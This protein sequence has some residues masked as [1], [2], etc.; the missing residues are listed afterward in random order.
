MKTLYKFKFVS[1]F[2]MLVLGVNQLSAQC[3]ASFTYTDMGNGVISFSNTSSFPDSSIF[4]VWEMSNGSYATGDNPSQTFYNGWYEVCLTIND[5]IFGGTCTSTI[6][7]SVEVTSGIA[8]PIDSCTIDATYTVVDNGNGVYSFV[9]TVTGGTPP[10]SYSWQFGD[11]TDS[12]IDNP[13]HTYANDGILNVCLTVIDS[14]TN[15]SSVYCQN[16]SVMGDPCG[17]NVYAAD[18]LQYGVFEAYNVSVNCFWDFGDGE[19]SSDS[20]NYQEHFYSSPGTY[21]YCVTI[22]NCPLICD[23]ILIGACNLVSNFS[24]T[25][26]GNGNYSFTNL[27]SGIA[28]TF[29]WNFGDGNTSNNTNPNHTFNANGVYVVVLAITDSIGGCIDYYTLTINV[30]GVLNSTPCNAGFSMYTDSISSGV[31]VVNS[32]TGSNLT[33]FWDFGDGNTSTQ[34]YPSYTYST[35]GPFELCL[36]VTG[37][38][39]CTSTY[40][41]SISAGGTVFKGGG[42]TINVLQPVVTSIEELA[43]SIS[44]LTI[45][46]NPFQNNITISLGLIKETQVNVTV[47]DL[48]GSVVV[49]IADQ[50]MNGTNKLQWNAE[51]VSSGI[52]ILNVRTINTLKVEK[53]ILNR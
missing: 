46:P 29:E 34:A 27:S 26:N 22:G 12:S 53:L 43:N 32:S 5:T 30:T 39:N 17:V 24:Y 41:D 38:G 28:D 2:L 49:V 21:Y 47:T 45:Y 11:G 42:F 7:D 44:D 6:C 14:D 48:L 15:C 40:C 13:V 3:Q 50:K 37:D 25:D 16:L 51:G 33:Y 35:A 4:A 8:E 19:V 36:T 52:Y 20:S 10:Y 9:S 31:N 18:S 1:L 23:S